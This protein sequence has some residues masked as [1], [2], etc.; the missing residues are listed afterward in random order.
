MPSATLS[1]LTLF[2]PAVSH[3]NMFNLIAKPAWTLLLSRQLKNIV[4][5]RS[6]GSLSAEQVR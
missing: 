5:V 6:V 4:T 2:H 1:E 3:V